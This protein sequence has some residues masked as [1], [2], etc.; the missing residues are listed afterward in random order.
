MKKLIRPASILFCF[1]IVVIFFL[2]GM[3]LAK[4]VGAAKSQGLAGGAIVLF[5]GLVSAV[6]AFIVALVMVYQVRHG[7][8]VK[9]NWVFGIIFLLLVSLL[10]YRIKTLDKNEEPVND[11]PKKPTSPVP[12][13]QSLFSYNE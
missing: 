9:A 7:T 3:Y 5:Y 8:I 12:D 13:N 2:A 11:Y 6:I 1:L 4:L 10:A